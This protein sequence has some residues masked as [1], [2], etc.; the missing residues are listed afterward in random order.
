M[1]DTDLKRHDKAYSK[2][3]KISSQIELNR[4]EAETEEDRETMEIYHALLVYLYV[5]DHTRVHTDWR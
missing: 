1:S 3:M 2:A 5:D 4:E